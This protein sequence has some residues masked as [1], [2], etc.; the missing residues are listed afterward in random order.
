M[1]NITETSH[2][3]KLQKELEQEEFENEFRGSYNLTECCGAPFT[4]PG[5]PDS[6]L[7]GSCFEHTGPMDKEENVDYPE[8]KIIKDKDWF[9]G[10]WVNPQDSGDK[11]EN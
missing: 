8:R 11:N 2:F 10:V 4:K 7:C 6:D 1:G 3:E 5:Y 9:R